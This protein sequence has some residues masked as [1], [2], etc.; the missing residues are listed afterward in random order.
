MPDEILRTPAILKTS[1]DAKG[2][3]IVEMSDGVNTATHLPEGVADEAEAHKSAFAWF[4]KLFGGGDQ[5]K[6]PTPA[7]DADIEALGRR[8]LV[9]ETSFT[10]M[11]KA[12]GEAVSRLQAAEQH[13][14]MVEQ[15]CQ[16][17]EDEIV[18]LRRSAG[19]VAQAETAAAADAAG[20]PPAGGA[21]SLMAQVGEQQMGLGTD[22]AAAD[23]PAAAGPA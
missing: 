20:T 3:F 13:V 19:A 6:G 22:P 4:D 21:P 2:G 17:L 18:L 10:S 14:Q 12:L 23:N 15:H 9:L 5:P 8:V 7:S 1:G 16:Q 11:T